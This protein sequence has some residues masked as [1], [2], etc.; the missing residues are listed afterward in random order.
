MLLGFPRSS[1]VVALG[2]LCAPGVPGG[3]RKLSGPLALRRIGAQRPRVR[4]NTGV[5]ELYLASLEPLPTT[6]A[7]PERLR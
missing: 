5:R 4:L 7:A 6:T 3:L 1:C 2:F